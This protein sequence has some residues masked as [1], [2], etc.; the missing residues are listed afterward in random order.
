M[1]APLWIPFAMVANNGKLQ[2]AWPNIIQGIIVGLV[3]GM[4]S[5][6]VLLIRMD[7]RTAAEAKR[8]DQLVTAIEAI[9]KDYSMHD[10]ISQD[11]RRKLSERV[12]RLE[13]IEL[14]RSLK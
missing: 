12:S 9:R 7:E 8:M 6:Y 11:D 13:A 4:M 10:E 5:S 1:M 14:G 3:A 2:I